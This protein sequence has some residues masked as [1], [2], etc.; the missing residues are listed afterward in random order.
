MG[1]I[2]D[3]GGITE[4]ST[5]L[6]IPC[7]TLRNSTERP[8]TVEYG[9]NIL[10]GDNFELLKKSIKTIIDGKW[11]TGKVPELWDGLTSKRIINHILKIYEIKKN[12]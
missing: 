6:N 2:T 8:E 12:N 10:I 1:I 4:E 3:S 11:K 9:T 5:F 7:L